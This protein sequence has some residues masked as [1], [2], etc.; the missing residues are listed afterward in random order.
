M[1]EVK[2]NY[3]LKKLHYHRKQRYGMIMEYSP[4]NHYW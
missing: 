4:Q 1:T 2:G 3:I